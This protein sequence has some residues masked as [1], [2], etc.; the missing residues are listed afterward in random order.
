MQSK[1]VL[2]AAVMAAD[3]KTCDGTSGMPMK[4]IKLGKTLAGR[5]QVS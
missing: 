3:D 2:A 4:D 5:K 1:S